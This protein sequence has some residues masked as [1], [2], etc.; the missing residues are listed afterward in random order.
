MLVQIGCQSVIGKP[1]RPALSDCIR[2]VFIAANTC[3][4]KSLVMEAKRPSKNFVR[5]LRT[6]GGQFGLKRISS[7]DLQKRGE[8]KERERERVIFRSVAI[9]L[10]TF[11][12][13]SFYHIPT[14]SNFAL[15]LSLL[16]CCLPPDLNVLYLSAAPISITLL[17]ILLP[18]LSLMYSLNKANELHKRYSSNEYTADAV[19][20]VSITAN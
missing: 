7:S 13:C 11:L 15:S 1:A 19:M 10:P 2:Y 8:E 5:S 16:F 3:T 14:F 20:L 12:S 6:D 18:R 17:N 9:T 4:S